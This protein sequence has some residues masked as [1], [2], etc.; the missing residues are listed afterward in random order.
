[1]LVHLLS[2]RIGIQDVRCFHRIQPVQYGSVVAGPGSGLPDRRRL[3]RAA[4]EY[5]SCQ[6][7]SESSSAPEPASRVA[8]FVANDGAALTTPARQ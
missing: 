2:H 1:R 6:L 7:V 4:R 8:I 3:L 5:A